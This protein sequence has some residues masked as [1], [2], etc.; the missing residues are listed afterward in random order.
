M[1][2]SRYDDWYIS[3]EFDIALS[4]N[5]EV[6]KGCKIFKNSLKE[7]RDKNRTNTSLIGSEIQSQEYS[8]E[9][10][11]QCKEEFETFV[12]PIRDKVISRVLSEEYKPLDSNKKEILKSVMGSASSKNI[13]FNKVRDEWKYGDSYSQMIKSGEDFK[14]CLELSDKDVYSLQ[15]E[16][17]WD[18]IRNIFQ[19][20]IKRK[21]LSEKQVDEIS[22]NALNGI[23]D[24]KVAMEECTKKYGKA[25][26]NLSDDN[27]QNK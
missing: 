8:D 23:R 25:L 19:N 12:K 26:S 10:I 22:S 5:E 2:D 6:K 1:D 27:I 9:L 20:A 11:N 21:G 3:K 14:K 16:C 13:D 18:T 17:E 15:L 4:N 24:V 7:I